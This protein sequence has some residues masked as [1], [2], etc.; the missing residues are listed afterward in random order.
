ML[1]K[2]CRKKQSWRRRR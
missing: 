2:S 1:L